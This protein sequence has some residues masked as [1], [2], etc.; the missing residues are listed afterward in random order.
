MRLARHA[1]GSVV[2][3][4]RRA[5]GTRTWQKRAGP[6]AE[7]FAA[8]D[9]THYAV[10]S[11]LGLADAFLGLVARGWALPDFA[12]PWPRGPLPATARFAEVLVGQLDL[13]RRTGV[14]A[15]ADGVNAEVARYFADR[16]APD[17][18]PVTEAE[19]QAMRRAADALLARW[20]RVAPGGELRL[21]V[22]PPPAAT[23]SR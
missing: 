2:L 19:V 21:D 23:L 6:T 11:T 16:P 5:D 22:P 3:E 18:R 8:H 12:A 4:L 13:E 9:L 14:A 17:P 10:E 1:E 7:F 15:T 20:A